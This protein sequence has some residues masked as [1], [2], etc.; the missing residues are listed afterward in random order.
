MHEAAASWYQSQLLSPLGDGPRGYLDARGLGHIVRPTGHDTDDP[1]QVGYAPN[2]WTGLVDHLQAA[3]FTNSELEA[4]GLA[5][6]TRTENLVDRFRDRI[7]LPIRDAGGHVISFIGRA[8]DDRDD[9]TPKYLNS[10]T[11]A[12]Y[13]KANSLFGLGLHPLVDRRV[14]LVEGPFDV[15]GVHAAVPGIT[16]VA[17]CGTAF[18]EPQARILATAGVRE[19]VVAFDADQGGLAAA[20]KAYGTLRL[21]IEN[22]LF[23]RLPDGTDPAALAE[24]SPAVLAHGLTEGLVPLGDVVVDDRVAR[25]QERLD[26]A[27]DRSLAAHDLGA[28]IATMPTADVARQVARTSKSIG[29]LHSTMTAVVAD[30]I[31][32]SPTMPSVAGMAMDSARRTPQVATARAAF[33][34]RAAGEMGARWSSR[35]WPRPVTNSVNVQAVQRR[36]DAYGQ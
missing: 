23:A 20:V 5:V 13:Q 36:A 14:I 30:A 15:L 26:S 16:A 4:G 8:P 18:T 29:V 27:E 24:T 17:P 22:P 7:M 19:L 32:R 35:R 11:T 25:W 28:L 34:E 33:P 3:G 1:W 10:P 9:Q 31:D 6:R 21:H 12:I 2:N